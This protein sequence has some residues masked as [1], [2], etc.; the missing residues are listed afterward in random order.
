MRCRV[1]VI[2][3]HPICANCG[4]C[5]PIDENGDAWN[6]QSDEYEKRFGVK[7]CSMCGAGMLGRGVQLIYIEGEPCFDCGWDNNY[8]Y[9]HIED[10]VWC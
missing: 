4:H 6:S 3:K 9:F 10:I 2:K 1:M 7:G 8:D 5:F